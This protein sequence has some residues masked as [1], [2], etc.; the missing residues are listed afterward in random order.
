[1]GSKLRAVHPRTGVK[2]A[3]RFTIIVN[4]YDVEGIAQAVHTALEMPLDERRAR[5]ASLR[6]TVE[7]Q[8]VTAWADSFLVALHDARSG[9][10]APPDDLDALDG[11]D[12]PLP[13]LPPRRKRSS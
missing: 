12:L 3:R 6:R 7:E 5:H 13:E 1:M 4:P 11:E 10:R 2:I 9:R 8:D